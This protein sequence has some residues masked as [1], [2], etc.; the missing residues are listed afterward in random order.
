MKKL[1]LS[2]LALL[3]MAASAFSQ[4]IVVPPNL[5]GTT[6]FPFTYLSDFI[7]A[8]TAANGDQMHTVYQLETG[9]V[10]FFTGQKNW[11]FDVRLEAVGDPDNGKPLVSRINTAGG[12]AL[13]PIYRGFGNF[14]W[15]GIY[16][17]MG[18]EGAD[19]AQYET[20]PFRPEGNDKRFIFNNCI[21]EKSRQGTI[22]IEG[23]NAK[24]YLTNCI[25]RNFGDFEKF[26]GNG[27]LVDT[28]EN[29]TD[30]VVIHNC[31]AHNIL[32]RLFI[33]FRQQGLNYFEFTNNTIFN[34]IGTFGMIQLNNTKESI[35]KDNLFMNP[36]MIGTSPTLAAEQI[37]YQNIVSY[38]FTIDTLVEGA[39]MD[40]SNNNIFWT[41]DVLDYYATS[42]SVSQPP[43]LSPEVEGMLA[44]P[45]SAYFTEVLELNNVPDRAPLI[46]YCQEAIMYRDSVGITDIMVED[47]SFAGTPWDKGYLFDFSQFDPCYSNTTMSA[48]A[49]SDGGPVGVRFLCDYTSPTSERAYNPDLNLTS[50]PNPASGSTQLSFHLQQGGQINLSVFDLN[51]RLVSTLFNGTLPAGSHTASWENL[52]NISKGM[53]FANLQTA[54]GRMFV[55]IFVQ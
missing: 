15:D 16:I 47:I 6:M 28:R 12:T 30:T 40:M 39:S 1:Y 31:V 37:T 27:R 41:Q 51:G 25:I 55:K 48:T 7:D 19:A 35:I 8:D 13:A 4:S 29:F 49:A 14:E 42:D 21:I 44:D 2:I 32:D 11:E 22:R 9:G 26:G 50:A 43:I 17:I 18:E 34:H 5:D 24:V 36:S 10:Y 3:F 33:G 38:L 46:Q 52:D 53:Y 45:S 54:Q 20:A 23:E